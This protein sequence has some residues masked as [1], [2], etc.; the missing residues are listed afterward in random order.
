MQPLIPY[1]EP[2][3]IPLFGD[4]AIH[5]FGILVATAFIVG[6]RA[7]MNKCERENL[8]PDIINRLTT[9]LVVGVFV[10]GHLGDVLF[11]RPA[12]YLQDPIEI[13][14]VW[15]GMSSFGGFIGC[16][17]LTIWFFRKEKV[18]FFPY[19]D[20]LCYGAS[21]A[22]VFG[23]LGCFSAHDHPGIETDFY[24]GVY[25]ICPGY[26]G[27]DITACHDMGLYEAIWAGCTYLLFR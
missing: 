2:F 8:D 26:E 20:T 17:L 12:E 14:K 6:I 19:G 15:K 22:W 16:T 3:R 10:G 4:V 11:Y 5:G 27:S 25:G 9:W 18:P 13:L 24:L 23:R 7:A 1:F 21:I